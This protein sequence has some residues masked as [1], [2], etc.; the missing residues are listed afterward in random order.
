MRHPPEGDK[1]RWR[2]SFS[3]FLD[4]AS[5]VSVSRAVEWAQWFLKQGDAHPLKAIGIVATIIVF[6]SA[7]AGQRRMGASR[8]YGAQLS[9]RPKSIISE[10]HSWGLQRLNKRFYRTKETSRVAPVTS[11]VTVTIA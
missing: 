11:P 10:L 2:K 6:G 3:T 8:C 1:V 9:T 7:I 5:A 4:S